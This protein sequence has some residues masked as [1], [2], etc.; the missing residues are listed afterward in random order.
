MK[1][2]GIFGKGKPISFGGQPFI[3]HHEMNHIP[4][5]CELGPRRHCQPIREYVPSGDKPSFGRL[6]YFA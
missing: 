6:E 4:T 5:G 2:G 3:R 1:I